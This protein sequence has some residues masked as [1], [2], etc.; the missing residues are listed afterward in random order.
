MFLRYTIN[1]IKFLCIT[2]FI[3]S[4]CFASMGNFDLINSFVVFSSIILISLVLLQVRFKLLL[5][6]SLADKMYYLFLFIGLLSTIYLQVFG[7]FTS[8]L[9]YFLYY[10]VL[11]VLPLNVQDYKIYFKSFFSAGFITIFMDI[12]N[13]SLGFT[14]RAGIFGNTNSR[15]VFYSTFTIF[16][17]GLIFKYAK[18]HKKLKSL[19]LLT[20][21]TYTFYISIITKSR[22][23]FLSM[24]FVLSLLFLPHIYKVLTSKIFFKNAILKFILTGISVI[25]I[26]F[27][28]YN[29]GL[30]ELIQDNIINKFDSTLGQ[31]NVTSGRSDIW[32]YYLENS[33]WIGRPSKFWSNNIEF[34]AHNSFLQITA[35]YGYLSGICFLAYWILNAITAIK[36]YFIE[37][38]Y[39][40][41]A[42]L[43]FVGVYIFIIISMAEEVTNSIPIYLSLLCIGYI[44]HS[45]SYIKKDD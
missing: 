28:I 35:I 19:V 1:F 42:I 24:L 3:L 39:N 41:K 22:T 18:E 25:G 16:L 6:F 4:G 38:Y 43:L 7:N 37:Y 20:F 5:P 23:S 8:L 11:V 14:S 27:L 21:A 29:L 15:G 31:G 33:T 2:I 34:S 30:K 44:R 12:F 32:R 40:T 13:I 17:V 36:Y 45:K 9:K 10:F 26:G